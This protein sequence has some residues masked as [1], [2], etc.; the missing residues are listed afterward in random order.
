MASHARSTTLTLPQARE[1]T[2]TLWP[3]LLMAL[4]GLAMV[5]PI[6]DGLGANLFLGW[7]IVF[8]GCAHIAACLHP[9][10]EGARFW[11]SWI[12]LTYVMGGL[13]VAL[14]PSLLLLPLTLA[15]SFIL[16]V[17]AALLALSF[18]RLGPH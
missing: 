2:N 10:M 7:L 12:G 4:G 16:S 6:G 15:T 3:F 1:R 17:E 8:S 14:Q 5:R 13:Y 9:G 11:R 18:F